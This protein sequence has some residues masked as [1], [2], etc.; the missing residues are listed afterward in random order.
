MHSK[1]N[2]V[3]PRNETQREADLY[4]ELALEKNKSDELDR[5]SFLWMWVA[6]LLA[7]G[8]LGWVIGMIL[9]GGTQC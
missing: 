2:D 6:V 8:H 3:R 7:I 5:Q 4:L 9:R 1:F